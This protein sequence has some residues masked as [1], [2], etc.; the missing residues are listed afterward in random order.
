[1]LTSLLAGAA[2]AVLLRPDP[3]AAAASSR[4][5]QI[6]DR[7]R[8]LPGAGSTDGKPM[9]PQTRARLQA[10]WNAGSP[11][12]Q[13]AVALDF[14]K[15][16][17]VEEIRDLLDH[18]MNFP[19]HSGEEIGIAA[20]LKRWLELEPQGALEYCRR[21]KPAF[22]ARLIG[23]WSQTQPVSAYELVLFMPA[24]SNQGSAW[25]EICKTTA[26]SDFGKACDL[27][28]KMPGLDLR[29]GTWQIDAVVNQMVAKDPEKALASLNTL[30]PS[31]LASARK[32]IASQLMRID[33]QRGW[34][35][36]RNQPNPLETTGAALAGAMGAD[37]VQA[38]GFMKSLPNAELMRVIE[39]SGSNWPLRK[40]NDFAE[41]L[42]QDAGLDPAAKQSIADRVFGRAM[43]TNPAEAQALLPLL[44]E[45]TQAARMREY[46]QN[47]SRQDAA[48]AKAWVESLPEG[49][50]R[51]SAQEAQA[52]FI[53]EPG[54]DSS[55]KRLDRNSPESLAVA[56]KQG[57]YI[58]P[59]DP[60][61]SRLT[62][63]QLGSIMAAR[64]ENRPYAPTQIL[65]GLSTS[66]PQAGA[67]WLES[68]PF[69]KTTG[70]LAAEFSARWASSDPA[71]AAAWVSKLPPGEVASTAAWN[72]ARQYSLY[73]PSA[74]EAW[75]RTLPV[76]SIQEAARQG[77][78][79]P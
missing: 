29:H 47:W 78:N 11:S 15:I 54:A 5:Q 49:P 72:V 55:G 3:E 41:A 30:P 28:G 51:L 79:P 33:P 23:D 42:T 61:L 45:G 40:V 60:R 34:D 35:W 1:M 38:L 70:L 9:L 2:T 39:Q 20:L 52:A 53:S 36:A 69:D 44:S 25:M 65:M 74:A 31:I 8:I 4:S 17:F 43:W 59:D 14:A 12:R 16:N 67:A 73:A 58:E 13:I 24:G 7:S 50:L 46:I 10:L 71:A 63:A 22:L 26:A 62:T 76:G 32:A 56:V 66:N 37:P 21:Q 77:L 6:S 57:Q 18:S 75:I 48:A 19:S 27:L 68:V 64:D